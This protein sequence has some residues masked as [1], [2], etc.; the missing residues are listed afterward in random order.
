MTWCVTRTIPKEGK[1]I[2]TILVYPWVKL[3]GGIVTVRWRGHLVNLKH[4]SETAD[5]NCSTSRPADLEDVR[6]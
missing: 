1:Q 5:A 3:A 2:L 6:L 4:L